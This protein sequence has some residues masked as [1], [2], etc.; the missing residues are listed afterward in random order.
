MIFTIESK[1]SNRGPG[2]GCFFDFSTMKYKL[3]QGGKNGQD[4]IKRQ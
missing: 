1:N 3:Y 2:H 4:C